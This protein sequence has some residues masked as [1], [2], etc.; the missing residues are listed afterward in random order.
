VAFKGETFQDG[1]LPDLRRF[2]GDDD[3]LFELV[4]LAKTVL[5][6]VAQFY[7]IPGKN[8]N[9]WFDEAR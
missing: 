8:D 6:L 4:P 3:K 2:K 1:K 7:R 5:S 9:K